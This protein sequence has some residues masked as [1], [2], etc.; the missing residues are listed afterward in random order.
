MKYAIDEQNRPSLNDCPSLSLAKLIGR[1]W[2]HR[3][4]ARPSMLEV[5]EELNTVTAEL[6]FA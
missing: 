5:C 4:K 6:A 3:A 2:A 1:C